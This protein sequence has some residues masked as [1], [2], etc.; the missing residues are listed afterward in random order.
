MPSEHNLANFRQR[1]HSA[2]AGASSAVKEIPLETEG[3]VFRQTF[4]YTVVDF[5]AE[6]GF[7]LD[8]FGLQTVALSHDY[9][10]FTTNGNDFH[11]SF[12]R[13]SAERQATVMSG[14]RLLLMTANI[15][16]ART[17]LTDGRRVPDLHES[18]GS[19]V[20]RV[21]HLTSPCGLPI[22]IWED[23]SPT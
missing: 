9:A 21:L 15:D 12:W 6:A 13:A 20:Q 7:F 8:V 17:H 22:D 16:S 18:M 3:V 1:F 11:I 5:E 10:L 23:P 19:P 4:E 2:L 14:L